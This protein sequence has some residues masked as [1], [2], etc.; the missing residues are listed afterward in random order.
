MEII[1]YVRKNGRRRNK[2]TKSKGLVRGRAKK[3][4]LFCGID[5]D[6][7]QSVI[8]GF[9]LCHSTDRFD[10]VGGKRTLNKETGKMVYVGGEKVDGFGL[11]TAKCRAEKWKFHTDYFVQK[12][13]K[14][15]EM[16]DAC[17]VAKYSLMQIINPDP[18]SII[19]IPPSIMV[20]LKPF[21]K[22]CRSYFVDKEFPLWIRKIETEDSYPDSNLSYEDVTDK[23]D[24]YNKAC[25]CC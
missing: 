2:E 10:Y 19:D 21:I 17:V 3:G 25:N 18:K 9:S 5:P 24:F 22:R 20:H 16:I 13:F 14:E 6:D 15:S 1:E 12:T 7:D 4:V 8:I 11:E 23:Y